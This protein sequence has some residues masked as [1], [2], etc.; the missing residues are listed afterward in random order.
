MGYTPSDDDVW[1]E[2][3]PAFGRGPVPPLHWIAMTPIPDSIP[4]VLTVRYNDSL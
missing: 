3:G 1:A 2:A 4:S